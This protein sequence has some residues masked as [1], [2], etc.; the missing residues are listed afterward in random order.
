MANNAAAGEMLEIT[1]PD[2]SKRQYP[3]GTRQGSGP[4]DDPDCYRQLTRFGSLIDPMFDLAGL[5]GTE[6]Q[7]DVVGDVGCA[8]RMH[9]GRRQ[10]LEDR[11]DTPGEGW[12]ISLD[13][14]SP[15]GDVASC[16]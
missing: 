3:R 2:G 12:F 1:L 16:R 13:L 15:H 10:C 7:A 6:Q 11:F 4:V 9:I 5:R 8:C 14:S